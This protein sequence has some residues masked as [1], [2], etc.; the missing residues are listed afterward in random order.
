MVDFAKIGAFVP[1][2]KQ[3][4]DHPCDERN[5][6]FDV[7]RMWETRDRGNMGFAPASMPAKVIPINLGALLVPKNLREASALIV[8]LFNCPQAEKH[9]GS[10]PATYKVVKANG[11]SMESRHS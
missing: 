7:A 9:R 6:Y 10:K 8:A 4:S 3:L 1:T 5:P 11:S 2:P